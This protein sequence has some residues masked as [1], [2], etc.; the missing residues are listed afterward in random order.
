MTLTAPTRLGFSQM[1]LAMF[2]PKCACGN[3]LNG[4][5]QK[6]HVCKYTA[7]KN[8]QRGFMADYRAAN[9]ERELSAV[10]RAVDR[11]GGM[12]SSHPRVVDLNKCRDLVS[13]EISP[14]VMA[15]IRE[16]A[17]LAGVDLNDIL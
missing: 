8:Y 1:F 12:F 15:M 4:R 7:F 11:V 5:E 14:D 9:P 6:C 13:Q 16:E 10:L 17:A 3:E 2:A